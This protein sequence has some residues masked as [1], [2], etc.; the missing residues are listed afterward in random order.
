MEVGRECE[1]GSMKSDSLLPHP[2]YKKV[3]PIS[4]AIKMHTIFILVFCEII[5][6]I[7]VP[8]EKIPLGIDIVSHPA[9]LNSSSQL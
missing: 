8:C 3:L 2:L 4:L 6:F 9:L 1:E 5:T 7:L